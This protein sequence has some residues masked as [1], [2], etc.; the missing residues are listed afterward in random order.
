V[1]W[2]DL[3]LLAVVALFGLRG[4]FRGLFREVLSVAGLIIG[5]IAAVRYDETVAAFGQVYWDLSPLILKGIAFVAIFFVVY[6]LFSLAG[7]LLHHSESVLL[8]QTVNRVGGIAIGIGKGAAITALI[9]FF[10][11]SWLPVGARDKLEGAYLV[12]PLAQL[13]EGI[14]KIGKQKL[15]PKEGGQAHARPRQRFV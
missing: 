6:F 11:A 12:A 8:L 4:Y 9:I 2:I 14:V 15:F 3:T 5:F 1:N 10:A 7:W 13:A